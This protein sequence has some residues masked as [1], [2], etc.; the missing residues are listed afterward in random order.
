M[1]IENLF[2]FQTSLKEREACCCTNRNANDFGTT[3]YV[4]GERDNEGFIGKADAEKVLSDLPLS[5]K[6]QK[7]YIAVFRDEKGNIVST[8]VVDLPR[9]MRVFYR[10]GDCGEIQKDYSYKIM[11]PIGAKKITYRVPHALLD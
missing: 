6:P 2:E 10:N 5:D 3:F 4:T 8:G 11:K 1:N 7:G 9:P